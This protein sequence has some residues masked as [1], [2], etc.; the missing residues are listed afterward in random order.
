MLFPSQTNE[1]PSIPG[2][3]VI[4][5]ADWRGPELMTRNDWVYQLDDADVADLET[6][7]AH[8]EQNA[9]DLISLTRDH[10]PLKRF[11][12]KLNAVRRQ[13]NEGLGLALIRGLPI[14]RYTREQAAAIY[15]GVGVHL[16]DPI[17]QN[18]KGHLLGHIVNLGS[19]MSNPN[20]RGSESKDALRYHTDDGDIIGLFCLHE[21]KAG[22][23]STLAS[24]V[25]IHN[26]IQAARPDLLRVLYRPF[27][28]DR[29]NEIPEGAEPYYAMPIYTY[30]DGRLMAWLQ[31]GYTASAQ[32]FP[33]VPRFTEL[34]M[35]AMKLIETLA[36][37]P[38]FRLN[39]GFRRGDMQFLNNHVI[40]HSRTEF[41]DYP[42]LERRRH[43]LRLWL[44]CA[45]TRALSPWHKACH[46]PGTRGGVYLKG[47]VPNI[48]IGPV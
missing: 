10:F 1:E 22:G 23:V 14:D 46:A 39:M 26:A 45:E 25:A 2:G 7:L 12:D 28:I 30:H 38:R 9:S 40:L 47:M 15:W 48:P 13:L 27:Y 36:D 17:A 33:E 44:S 41:E 3:P 8:A 29:R 32:R 11:G 31:P 4:D 6:A 5:P 20:Q 24:A 42:E 34:Q 21:A 43:L 19:T 35:E 18:S 37:D 16:G